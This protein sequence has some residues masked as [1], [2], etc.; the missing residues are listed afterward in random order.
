MDP[1]SIPL[2]FLQDQRRTNRGTWNCWNLSVIQFAL[3]VSLNLSIIVLNTQTCGFLQKRFPRDNLFWHFKYAL[4]YHNEAGPCT[5]SLNLLVSLLNIIVACIHEVMPTNRFKLPVL[6]LMYS[7][8][9]ESMKKY[10]KL[11][12]HLKHTK[13][14]CPNSTRTYHKRPNFKCMLV[15]WHGVQYALR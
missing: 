1:N 2:L 11:C 5:A 12:N 10:E 13:Q 9:Y 15:P 7:Q 4:L 3:L 6:L 8:Q 14:I